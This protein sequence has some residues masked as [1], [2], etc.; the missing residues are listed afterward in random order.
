MQAFI[1]HG[2]ETGLIMS[3]LYD[4]YFNFLR[5]CNFPKWLSHFPFSLPVSGRFSCSTSLLILGTESLPNK[6]T[7]ISHCSS[8]FYFPNYVKYL[9]LCLFE[10][11]ILSLAMCPF[12]Y[13][14]HLVFKFE[15]FA[16]L[17]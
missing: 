14:T 11:L 7:A 16:F 2:R 10:I 6:G 8:N 12:K 5:N 9:L 4:R 3:G 17:V 15:L 13:F 1:C